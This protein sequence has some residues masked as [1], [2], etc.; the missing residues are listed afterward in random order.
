MPNNP[1]P[2]TIGIDLGGTQVRAGLVRDGQV[3]ARAARFFLTYS[4]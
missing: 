2:L 3:L 4:L 1:P